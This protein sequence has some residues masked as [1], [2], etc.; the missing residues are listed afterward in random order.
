VAPAAVPPAAAAATD[1]PPAPLDPHHREGLHQAAAHCWNRAQRAL[2]CAAR[3]APDGPAA[4]DLASVR[5]V[6]RQLRVLAKWPRD[7][8]AHLALGRA[9]F[10][11]GLGP[12]AEHAFAQAGALAPE[13]P[14]PHVLLT[15]EYVYRGDLAAAERS[16]AAAQARDA[17]LPPLATIFADLQAPPTDTRAPATDEA[18]HP[19]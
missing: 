4:A 18:P 7:V 9:Y 2:E 16:Y 5:A 19:A 10:E 13:A 11:L 3:A 8:P 1:P 14:A 17:D 12:D 6:R 15:L